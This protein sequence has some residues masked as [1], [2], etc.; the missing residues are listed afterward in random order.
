MSRPTL[1]DEARSQLTMQLM[2]AR[3]DVGIALRAKNKTERSARRIVDEVKVALGE[4][5][6][7]WWEDGDRNY[8]RYMVK[9][10]PYRDWYEGLP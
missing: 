9:N 5:G 4:R 1:S 10:T 2:K 6:E 3:R 7:P 8:N